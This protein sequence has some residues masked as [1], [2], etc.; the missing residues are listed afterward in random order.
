ML[1]NGTIFNDKLT[2]NPDYKVTPL[3]DVNISESQQ[4]YEV[5][6]E[7]MDYG[8]NTNSYLYNIGLHANSRLSFRITLSDLV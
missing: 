2:S 8:T 4:R 5:G 3:F 1:S 6:L 7:T